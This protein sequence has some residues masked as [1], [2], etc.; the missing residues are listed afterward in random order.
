MANAR[1][2]AID[3]T[4]LSIDQAEERGFIHRDY[5]AHCLRWSHVAKYLNEKQRYKTNHIL[6]IGCGRDQPLPRLMY[7]SRLIP[8]TG[9]YTG[10]DYNNLKQHEMFHTGKFPITLKGNVAFPDVALERS[11]YDTIICFEVLEHVEP[12]HSLKMLQGIKRY[13]AADGRAFISTPCYDERTGAAANHVNE[14]TYTALGS[15]IEHAGLTA[16]R[17]WGT[18]AS[19]KDYKHTLSPATLQIFEELSEYYD[20]NYLATIFAP[21]FP[22]K[23]RN[24]LWRLRARDLGDPPRFPE[25]SALSSPGNSSS[26]EWVNFIQGLT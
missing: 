26:A 15:M 2:K 11:S 16:E 19:Q 4:H 9:S 7:T 18:F 6:D 24:C 3:N 1:N 12:A 25:L 17:V 22:E 8:V 21:L 5:I 14:M 13:L 20:S 23:A 10:V